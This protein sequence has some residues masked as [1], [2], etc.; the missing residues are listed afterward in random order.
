MDGSRIKE[1]MKQSKNKNIKKGTQKIKML[2]NSEVHNFNTGSKNNVKK[3]RT[4][5]KITQKLF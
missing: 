5:L 3:P 4:L 2:R 1:G